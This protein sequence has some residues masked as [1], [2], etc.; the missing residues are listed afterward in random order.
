MGRFIARRLIQAVFVL[1]GISTALFFLLRVSGDPVALLV[2]ENATP[3]QV[4]MMREALGLNEPIFIQYAKFMGGIVSNGQLNCVDRRDGQGQ[5]VG[6]QCQSS[7]FGDSL[8][9]KRDSLKMV[10]DA[11]PNTIVLSFAALIIGL[12]VAFPVGIYAALNRN[13]FGAFFASLFA[14]VGQSM[15]SFWLGIMLILIFAVQLR[16]LPSFGTGTIQHL[17]L[18]A[19]TLSAFIM[20]RHSR[21]IRSGMLEVLNQDYIRTARA[22][23]VSGRHVITRHAMKN[24]LIPIVTVLGLDI[25]FLIS[26]AIIIETV[27]SWPGMGR[28]LIQA[29]NGRD[30]PVVQATVFVIAA[31]VVVTNLLVDIIYGW[32]DPRISIS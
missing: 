23:G 25:S 8:V 27:F 15:P 3:Q 32:L 22:K 28:Q 6:R 31:V 9:T 5:V 24:T 20:A 12:V 14:L 1:V 26:G 10:W 16:W 17:I 29:V 30:Y 4:E 19:V 2:G 18:P 11:L 7:A 13:T 21:L